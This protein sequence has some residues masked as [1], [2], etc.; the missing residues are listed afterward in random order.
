MVMAIVC[1]VVL[2]CLPLAQTTAIQKCVYVFYTSW[3]VTKHTTLTT[4]TFSGGRIPM[5]VKLQL[6]S[7]LHFLQ[8]L[9]TEESL[10]NREYRSFLKK[11]LWLLQKHMGMWQ[12]AAIANLLQRHCFQFVLQMVCR[13]LMPI[14]TECVIQG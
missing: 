9:S 3:F 1:P 13:L 4:K 8:A 5:V 7:L 10:R 14:C 2:V 6:K 12:V 11:N